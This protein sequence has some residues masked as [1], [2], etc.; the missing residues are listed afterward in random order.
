MWKSWYSC[1]TSENQTNLDN[2]LEVLHT[3]SSWAASPTAH[4]SLSGVMP[5]LLSR[6]I[7]LNIRRD[8]D[9]HGLS[10]QNRPTTAPKLQDMI[11]SIPVDPAATS[12]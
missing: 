2:I 9:V 7:T 3:S 1:L 5:T 8:R 10:M 12:W 6:K 11:P 4:L